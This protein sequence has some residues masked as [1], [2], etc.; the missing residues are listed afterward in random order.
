MR[1]VDKV[2]EIC[3]KRGIAISQLEKD[4]GFGNA[5]IS[6]LKKSLPSDRLYKI[7]KYLDVPITYF[8]EDDCSTLESENPILSKMDDKIKKYAVKLSRMDKEKQEQIMSLI[9][10]LDNKN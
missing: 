9:D 2:I 7:S 6:G 5:Y 8:L 3:E 4:C 10:M 1:D